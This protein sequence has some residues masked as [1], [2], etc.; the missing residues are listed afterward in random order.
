MFRNKKLQIALAVVFFLL[1][2][3]ITLQFKSVY[4]NSAMSGL[5]FQRLE[6][7]QKE[8]IKEQEKN[9]DLNKQLLEANNNLQIYRNEAEQN[10]E[11]NKALITEMERY[12]ILAGLTEVT[13]PGVTVTV[14]DS[15]AA[16]SDSFTESA[17]IIHDSDLRSIVNELNSAGAEAISINGERIVSNSEIR[18]VG[19]TVTINGNKYAPPFVIKAIGESSTMEAALNIRGGVVEELRFYNLEIKVSKTAKL[20][21]GKYNGI[22]NFKYAEPVK[23][24]DTTSDN[25][26]KN[27]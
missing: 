8:L 18:C 22:L 3:T 1:S 21:I 19:S 25:K 15:K 27:R 17:Y 24:V 11:G 23:T 26:Q 12:M 13:G 2:F 20:T 5:Q 16:S 7:V 4:K 14:S 6:E 10:T 9:V